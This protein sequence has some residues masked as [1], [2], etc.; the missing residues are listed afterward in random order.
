MS[1]FYR[2]NHDCFGNP[3]YVPDGYPIPETDDTPLLHGA[4][5][6]VWIGALT[7]GDPD[8]WMVDADMNAWAEA[9]EQD[10]DDPIG[11]CE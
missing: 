10:E 6:G 9:N 3:T 8:L 4:T 7:S 2:S 11:E 1:K 5:P